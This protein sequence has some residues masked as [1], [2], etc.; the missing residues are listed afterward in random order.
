[1]TELHQRVNVPLLC[2][3]INFFFFFPDLKA[4]TGSVGMKEMKNNE[5]ISH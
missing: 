3:S 1:M 5:H 4:L 2:K